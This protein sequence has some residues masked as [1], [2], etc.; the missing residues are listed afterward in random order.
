MLQHWQIKIR[1]ELGACI[2]VHKIVILIEFNHNIAWFNN[3]YRL[4]MSATVQG[5][6]FTGRNFCCKDFPSIF[7]VELPHSVKR[8]LYL[9]GA[10]LVVKISCV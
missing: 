2:I 5:V 6:S 3:Q 9:C 1:E 4:E 8:H 10:C 7:A